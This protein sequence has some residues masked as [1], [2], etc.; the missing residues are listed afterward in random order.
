MS[1]E[2][3]AFQL[4]GVA[5]HDDS[6]T[7]RVDHM[8]DVSA[9][10]RRRHDLRSRRT[11]RRLGSRARPRSCP[12]TRAPERAARGR[13]ARG[14]SAGRGHCAWRTWPSEAAGDDRHRA[15][16]PVSHPHDTALRRRRAYSTWPRLGPDDDASTR[17][18]QRLVDERVRLGVVAIHRVGVRNTSVFHTRPTPGGQL[19]RSPVNSGQRLAVPGDGKSAG[20][21]G[22]AGVGRG[23][24]LESNQRPHPDQGWPLSRYL[25]W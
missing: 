12:R 9:S 25:T 7:P 8:P 18:R 23:G 20:Q 4:S 1:C 17:C 16:D 6:H 11:R 19:R 3:P 14:R 21:Q 13:R 22:V 10:R 2:N 15:A 24:W 5:S